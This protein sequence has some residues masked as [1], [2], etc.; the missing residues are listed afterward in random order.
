MPLPRPLS[1][2]LSQRLSRLLFILAG[3]ASATVAAQTASP[4]APA[5]AAAEPRL[6]SRDELR[7]CMATEGQLAA[8]REQ[9]MA[10][11]K[12][13]QEEIAAIRA[14]AAQM[15]EDRKLIRD[16]EHAKQDRFERRRKTHNARV[17]AAQTVNAAVRADLEALNKDLT[18]YNGSC[19][20]IA[21]LPE[22]RAAILKEREAAKAN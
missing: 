18:A 3:L 21:F 10:R 7:Q 2:C 12:A 4:A 15:D 20:R 22:D 11:S 19:G 1:L 14:E 13:S 9:V 5:A 8:R 6:V 16:D 17:Q